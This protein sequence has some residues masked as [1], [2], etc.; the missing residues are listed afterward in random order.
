MLGDEKFTSGRESMPDQSGK[1][2]LITRSDFDGL[3]CAILL[4]EMDLIDEITLQRI[5]PTF[6]RH[7]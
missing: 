7:I 2:R 6:Q 5:C 4:K 3:V 1:Y